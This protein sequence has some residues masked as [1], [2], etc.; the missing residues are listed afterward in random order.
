[1]YFEDRHL[2]TFDFIADA[3]RDDLVLI[4]GV[5]AEV[6]TTIRRWRIRATSD[7]WFAP[8]AFTVIC[9]CF[10][11]TLRALIAPGSRVIIDPTEHVSQPG[12]GIDVVH[13]VTIRSYMKAARGDQKRLR[14]GVTS[15]RRVPENY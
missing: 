4:G 1:M 14:A 2:D 6:P 5:L 3:F 12:L 11:G 7:R 15:L 10:P 8:R 9:P 13:F